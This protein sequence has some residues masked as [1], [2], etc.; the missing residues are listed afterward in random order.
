M[1]MRYDTRTTEQ[2]E[3]WSPV[4]SLGPSLLHC[5]APSVID[6]VVLFLLPFFLWLNFLSFPHVP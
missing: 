2:W 1:C 5:D 4:L 3:V 6:I